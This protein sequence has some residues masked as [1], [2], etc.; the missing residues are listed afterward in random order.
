[1]NQ[2][3]SEL[4]DLFGVTSNEEAVSQLGKVIPLAS[5]ISIIGPAAQKELEESFDLDKIIN[6]T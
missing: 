2:V 4:R 3:M 5:R 6:S 1:M